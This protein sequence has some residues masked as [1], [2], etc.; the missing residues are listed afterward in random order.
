MERGFGEKDG[1]VFGSLGDEGYLVD[2]KVEDLE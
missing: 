1:G 2:E